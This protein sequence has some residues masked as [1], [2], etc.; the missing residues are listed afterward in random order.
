LNPDQKKII[1]IDQKE[2]QYSNQL[3]FDELYREGYG[4]YLQKDYARAMESFEKALGIDP[5]NAEVNK[6][7]FAAKQRA[8]AK[9]EPLTGV[10]K[11]KFDQARD[12]YRDG[13]Y[14]EALL[15]FQEIEKEKPYNKSVLDFID[16]A[17][18]KIEQ[19]KRRPNQ[20]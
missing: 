5:K 18:E 15:L 2:N 11:Q 9:K 19:Q 17:Q 6:L 7:F 10:Q 14:N 13:K 4:Y 1:L 12:L 3:S 20:P 8:N 16:M